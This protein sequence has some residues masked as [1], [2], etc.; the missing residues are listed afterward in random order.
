MA[1]LN[2]A[3]SLLHQ[4]LIRRERVWRQRARS[5]C[6]KMK[7]HNT[8]FFYASTLFKKQKNEII[9]IHINGRN[10]QG[11]EN[12]KAEIRSFFAQSFSQEP[13]PEFDFS[14]DNHPKITE[15]QSIFLEKTPSREEKVESPTSIDQYRPISVVGALYKIISKIL[16]S[17]LREVIA[18]L[19][20]ESQSAFVMNRQILDGVL[21]AKES[22]R[23][24]K[25]RKIPGTLI[26]L[27]FQKAYDSV[28]W[29]FLKQVMV[30]LGFGRKM[31]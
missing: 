26:K 10:I 15:A 4:W 13:V 9:Q 28:N 19:I 17:R 11:V 5:Y 30:K 31:D 23:W 20:D 29:S 2:A 22:L 18:P 16:S 1:R 24:L 14:L 25:K 21:I 12:L 6:F 27:D 8:K 3:N 7:D